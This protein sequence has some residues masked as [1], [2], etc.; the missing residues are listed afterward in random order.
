M[1]GKS[2]HGHFGTVKCLQIRKYD[3]IKISF[4]PT[5]VN[6]LIDWDA[7]EPGELTKKVLKFAETPYKYSIR[8]L[9]PAERNNL[10]VGPGENTTVTDGK[11][12]FTKLHCCNFSTIF[13]FSRTN[14]NGTCR[15]EK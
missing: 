1:S 12:C 15:Y 2:R 5:K 14:S 11:I 10:Y 8:K 7:S 9:G 4:L 13:S 6:R 3:Q